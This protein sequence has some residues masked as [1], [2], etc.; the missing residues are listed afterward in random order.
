MKS[1]IGV[2]VCLWEA[3]WFA[4]EA[5]RLGSKMFVEMLMW[6]PNKFLGYEDICHTG[7][8][9]SYRQDSVN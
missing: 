3:D 7:I 6:I 9:Y 8:N 2:R 1:F 4:S 5:T